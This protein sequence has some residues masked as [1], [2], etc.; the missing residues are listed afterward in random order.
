MRKYYVIVFI[1]AVKKLNK[2]I[3]EFLYVNKLLKIL[4]DKYISGSV[5]SV[6]S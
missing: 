1:W 5:Q 4:E 3:T 2:T 6:F